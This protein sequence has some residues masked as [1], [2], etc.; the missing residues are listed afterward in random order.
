MNAAGAILA[1]CVL[2]GCGDDDEPDDPDLDAGTDAIASQ[3]AAPM[4]PAPPQPPRL[5]P[6]PAGWLERLDEAS[7]VA[8][9]EPMPDGESS[10]PLGETYV[11]GEGCTVLGGTCPSDGFAPGLPATD[12]LFVREG[13]TGD[14]SR[15]RPFG[16][17]SDALAIAGSGATI[18][19]ARGTYRAPTLRRRDLT[20]IGVCATETS[21]GATSGARFGFTV[22][23]GDVAL[24][25]VEVIP[26]SG[27]AIVVANAELD[28]E[29]VVVREVR[30]AAIDVASAT[31]RARRLLVDG[32]GMLD[33]FPGYGLVIERGSAAHLERSVLQRANLG[34]LAFGDATVTI[35]S[36]ILRDA[37]DDGAA[38]GCIELQDGASL[39]LHES[40][41]ARC[42]GQ[43]ALAFSGSS[44]ALDHV[45]V[46][47]TRGA[48]SAAVG[49]Y[50]GATITIARTVLEGGQVGAVDVVGEGSTARITD[51][52][53]RAPGREDLA[54]NDESALVSA[55]RGG[56]IE[57]E[58]VTVHDAPCVGVGAL[59]SAVA[60]HDLGV[61]AITGTGEAACP[62]L[63]VAATRSHLDIERVAVEAA[64]SGAV[65]VEGGDARVA[66]LTVHDS[67]GSGLVLT[68]GG[69]LSLDR[70]HV[71]RIGQVALLA[72]TATIEA[73]DVEIDGVAAEARPGGLGLGIVAQLEGS[74]A[75]E[76]ARVGHTQLGAAIAT[77]GASLTVTDLLVH[78]VTPIECETCPPGFSAGLCA[79]R[80]G[81][82]S[83]TRFVV[84]RGGLCGAYVQEASELSLAMGSV[85][86]SAVGLC[87]EDPAFD[88]G[89]IERDVRFER[90]GENLG[91][92]SLPVPEIVVPTMNE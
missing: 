12:V 71:E 11:L 17:L 41:L 89:Q 76:R 63:A 80:G 18:A 9:C 58:R 50:T 8:L 81:A 59:D 22:E 25:R 54:P 43:G 40:L 51:L 42:E 7:G 82:F 19:L 49:A 92:S 13:A 27:G 23:G 72:S 14:G 62:G 56:A 60:L 86:E 47:D 52:V 45:V 79:M 29:D 78:D 32:V 6:C 4:P 39:E 70:M 75:L 15:E 83:A 35:E 10:C 53:A 30:G 57:G 90:N 3:I 48:T 33:A 68:E 73:R 5:T 91:A 88:L 34:M 36:S 28:L 66:D 67:L 2:A 77:H 74:I 38:K 24:R 65:Y 26:G 69:T 64:L 61:H 55:Y 21:V 44:L 31:L 20:L 46:R 84:E 16:T 37:F 87:V 85:A 1:A